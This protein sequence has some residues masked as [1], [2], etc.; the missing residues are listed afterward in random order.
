MNI[1]AEIILESK[2]NSYKYG[3]SGAIHR[4]DLIFEF[5]KNHAY[6]PTVTEA[7]DYSFGDG[8]DSSIKLESILTDDLGIGIE[9]R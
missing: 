2:L 4:S 8:R 3:V 9:R 7:L 6:Y 1:S 5:I